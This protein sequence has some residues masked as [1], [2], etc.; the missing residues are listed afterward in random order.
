MVFVKWC[1]TLLYKL[2]CVG[3]AVKLVN[4]NRIKSER[5]FSQVSK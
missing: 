3:L 5:V 2:C 1:T 4:K